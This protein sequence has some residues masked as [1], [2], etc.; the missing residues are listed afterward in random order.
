MTGR[1]GG[2]PWLVDA[3][4][5]LELRARGLG[6]KAIARELG[7][8][9]DRVRYVAKR[10]AAAATGTLV[11]RDRPPIRLVCAECGE[12][13]EAERRRQTPICSR[14]CKDRRYRRLHP[15]QERE[16]QR[17]KDARRRARKASE[18]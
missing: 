18:R 14:T 1:P 12:S 16:R 15:D 13:F 8:T 2:R 3:E 9:R 4:R 6:F 11:D 17:R 7:L 10:A 5:V